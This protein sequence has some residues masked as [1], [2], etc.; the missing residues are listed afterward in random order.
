MK[1]NKT[2]FKFIALGRTL[3]INFSYKNDEQAFLYIVFLSNIL[4]VKYESII[5]DVTITFNSINIFFKQEYD[6]K[7]IRL[8]ILKTIDD[9]EYIPSGQSNKWK[10]PVCLDDKFTR[11]LY[12]FLN[13]NKKDVDLFLNKFLTL[14]F[15][16]VFYGFL[17][18]FPYISRRPIEMAIER[19]TTPNTLTPKGSLAIGGS[20]VGIYPQDSPGGWHVIGNCPV[21]VIDFSNENKDYIMPGDQIQFY[22][23]TKSEHADVIDSIETNSEHPYLNLFCYD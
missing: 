17:P 15:R 6:L 13:E 14:Q 18:G 23:I 11:D 5:D 22:S 16:L 2:D 19:K 4:K 3:I 8:D 7:K 10:L 21:P 20:Q 12:I 1:Y 9:R